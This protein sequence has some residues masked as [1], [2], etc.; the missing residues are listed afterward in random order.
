MIEKQQKTLMRRRVTAIIVATALIVLLIPTLIAVNYI[1]KIDHFYDVDDTKYLIKYKNGIY[2]MYDTD[3]NLLRVDEEYGYYVTDSGTLVDVD[4]QTGEHKIFAVVDTEGNEAVG[5]NSRILIFP[6]LERKQVRSLE[7]FNDEGAIKFHR[8]NINKDAPDDSSDFII[9]GAPFAQYD[10]EIFSSL[11]V[12]TAYTLTKEK[13]EDPIKDENGEF[14]EYGLIDEVRYDSDGKEYNYSPAYYIITDMSGNKYKVIVGDALVTGGGYYAQYVDIDGE[15]E[16]KR[17]AV[18]V[19]DNTIGETIFEEVE[20]FVKPTLLYPMSLNTHFDVQN[21]IVRQKGVEKPIVGFSF[22]D[23]ADRQNTIYV[24]DSFKFTKDSLKG[25]QPNFNS[26]YNTLYNLYNISFAGV[27]YLNPTDEELVKCGIAKEVVKDGE[28]TIEFDPEYRV[29]FDYDALDDNGKFI[30]TVSQVIF[31]SAKNEN[32]NYYA[33]SLFYDKDNSGE[34]FLYSYDMVV[35]VEPQSL[36]FLGW[37]SYDWINPNI[38]ELNMAF[39]EKI[40]IESNGYWAEFILDNSKNTTD[41]ITDATNQEIIGT[42][43]NGNFVHTLA[44]LDVIDKNGIV[45]TIT[46]NDITAVNSK[47]ETQKIST[48]Y[49]ARN[50]LDKQVKAVSGYIDARDGSRV[51]VS[52]NEVVVTL[53]NGQKVVYVRYATDLFKRYYQTLAVSSVEDTYIMSADEEAQDRELLLTITI[54]NIEGE[55]KEYKFYSLTSR[56]VYLTVNGVGG[57][58]ILSNRVDKFV[59][60]AQKF[61]DFELIDPTAKN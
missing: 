3:G 38:F 60:D 21:F 53:P 52:A 39:V 23:L 2:A 9:D 42:D 36:E 51:E 19:L 31:I 17:D 22:I 33:Y 27:E 6:H 26:M 41:D 35:E 24:H 54:T 37:D 4:A 5:A 14:S 61:F 16:T 13:I 50:M 58:Y 18:Y 7:I 45:W 28:K 29:S 40:K 55:V 59:S 30:Q 48:A 12:S 1:I 11:F 34:R 10:P 8:Y 43:S 57:F 20:H 25:Y 32:G 47:G 56:K 15:S 44:V 46:P 49:H